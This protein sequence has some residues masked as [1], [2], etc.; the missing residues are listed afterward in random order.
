MKF[1]IYSRIELIEAVEK[2][3][4]LEKEAVIKYREIEREYRLLEKERDRLAALVADLL[5]QRNSAVSC[6]QRDENSLY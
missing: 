4:K 3:Q 2:A 1:Q 5:E 6:L